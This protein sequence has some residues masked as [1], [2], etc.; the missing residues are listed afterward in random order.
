MHQAVFNGYVEQRAVSKVRICGAGSIWIPQ[1]S[2]ESRARSL[3][4]LFHLRDPWPVAGCV[5][6]QAAPEWVDS[7]CKELVERRLVRLQP[8]RVMQQ[9]PVESFE[10]AEIKDQAVAL[11]NRPAVKRVRREKA[12]KG[13]GTRACALN[14][15]E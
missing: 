11:R 7:K 9:I 4:V 15:C 10:M 14:P 3:V 2:V 5:G 8:E 1:R 12:E 6:G 13:I